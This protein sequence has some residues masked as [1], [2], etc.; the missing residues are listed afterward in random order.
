MKTTISAAVSRT[1]PKPR[2]PMSHRWWITFKL[3]TQ[4][5][6]AIGDGT[7]IT[8]TDTEGNTREIGCVALDARGHP[9]LPATGWK[10]ALRALARQHTVSS[11]PDGAAIPEA[12]LHQLFGD[13]INE[14]HPGRVD[15]HNGYWDAA[16]LL[17]MENLSEVVPD[18]A[19]YVETSVSIDR[20]RGTA[21][22][23]HLFSAQRVP[24]GAAF[25]LSLMVQHT[26]ETAGRVLVQQ[27]LGLLDVADAA[28]GLALGSDAGRGYGRVKSSAIEVR[29]FGPKQFTKWAQSGCTGMWFDAAEKREPGLVPNTFQP[30]SHDPSLT[31]QI[32]FLG[33]YL[34]NEPSRTT[35]GQNAQSHTPRLDQNGHPVLPARTLHGALRSQSERI[36]RTLGIPF[37]EFGTPNVGPDDLIAELYGATNSASKLKLTHPPK[38][39]DPGVEHTQDF[40]AIDRFTGGGKEGAKFNAV[41]RYRPK[42]DVALTLKSEV[43]E[44]ARGLLLLTLRD[45]AEGDIPIGWGKRK[46]YGACTAVPN[47]SEGALALCAAQALTQD[48]GCAALAALRL[49][50]SN[51][52][53]EPSI[54]Q[55]VQALAAD[56]M[57]AANAVPLHQLP[58]EVAARFHNTYH[59]VPLDQGDLPDWA[60]A[61]D[62]KDNRKWK[63]TEGFGRHSHARYGQSTETVPLLSGR[64][65]CCLT[66]ETP[67][68][69]GGSQNT[70]AQ[71]THVNGYA[72]NGQEVLPATSIKGM[73]SSIAEAASGSALRVLDATRTLSYRK[74]RKDALSAIG[75]LRKIDCNGKT[76][77]VVQPLALPTIF[78]THAHAAEICDGQA[79][80]DNVVTHMGDPFATVDPKVYIG[81]Y[82]AHGVDGTGF[83]T[84]CTKTF[85]LGTREFYWLKLHPD[86]AW[87]TRRNDRGEFLLSQTP[88]VGASHTPISQAQ[89]D[90]LKPTDRD[91]YVRGILRVLGRFGVEKKPVP[92]NKKHELFIP[93]P[94]GIEN[95]SDTAM[96]PTL[97]SIAKTAWDRYHS[98]AS[99]AADREAYLPYAPQGTRSG[100][101]GAVNL[102]EGDLVFFKVKDNAIVELSMSMIWRHRVEN[103]VGQPVTVGDFVVKS[104]TAQPQ[105]RAS[106]A[107][108]MPSSQNLLPFSQHRT[109]VTPAEMLFG[110]VEVNAISPDTGTAPQAMGFTGKL[111]F[112]DAYPTNVP[113]QHHEPRVAKTL[114][115]PK[116]NGV[117]YF[118]RRNDNAY[119]RKEQ[120]S[121]DTH[122]V[123]GRK[124]FLHA[125][126]EKHPT[127]PAQRRVH[128]VND[129][130]LHDAGGLFP[131]VSHQSAENIEQKMT[132]RPMEIGT[133]FSF[134]VD[135]DN[136]TKEEFALLI[137]SL[138][139]DDE[140][141]HKLGLGKS[142]GLGSVRI[143][144]ESF[145]FVNRFERYFRHNLD[146]PRAD[147]VQVTEPL[148][149]AIIQKWGD[150]VLRGD[151]VKAQL[152]LGRMNAVVAP[153]VSPLRTRSHQANAEKETFAWFTHNDDT[154]HGPHHRQV[155]PDLDLDDQALPTM[156]RH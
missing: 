11:S 73:L 148:R 48:Q 70:A 41:S 18:N 151:A 66:A 108:V 52:P 85:Q 22:D 62:F 64:V 72:I 104:N 80:D 154:Q 131:W 25:N 78:T 63:D 129:A 74:S 58:G 38:C 124:S 122:V 95:L 143:D 99:E 126:T 141:R 123:R 128:K 44:A 93:Y 9:Y 137:Y 116:L 113:L 29:E 136:L 50:A 12:V 97:F 88:K 144:I 4:T 60:K 84:A 75:M 112:T 79:F 10:G 101:T 77:Y 6:L 102:L 34:V 47:Q 71:P 109:H 65:S 98:L 57:P 91:E 16:P 24:L 46:G 56:F 45:L 14:R 36:L 40:I 2:T 59:F 33:L 127:N 87:H 103:A 115:S 130:G 118:K 1:T 42:F 139:P 28:G 90:L 19:Y 146:A 133:Q 27:L 69:V 145:E 121:T 110:F 26:D 142:I 23:R 15:F 135:F 82:T 106:Q 32:Q 49:L 152:V 53:E 119:F 134:T 54:A 17:G 117:L 39:V 81:N 83:L 125:W 111:R 61:S 120:L 8:K 31:F 13:A 55:T 149:N 30:T 86:I 155:L 147:I 96:N 114:S 43:S 100:G 153:V 138:R 107:H 20:H 92:N 37:A 140:Y 21:L 68:L 94:D 132:I 51:G 67:F 89:Y 7:V 105:H 3:T 35:T 156:N 5:P 150:G 76:H